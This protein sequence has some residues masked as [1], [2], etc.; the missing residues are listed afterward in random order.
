MNG[1][2]SIMSMV[3]LLLLLVAVLLSSWLLNNQA[4]LAYSC[5]ALPYTYL[6]LL[7]Y[8]IWS[9]QVVA[10]I[11]VVNVVLWSGGYHRHCHR[12]SLV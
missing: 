6:T 9:F 8:G 11:G 4:A 10:V 3:S 7:K 1:Y 2:S 5:L 12:L